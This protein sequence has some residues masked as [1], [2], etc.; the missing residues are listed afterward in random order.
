MS[1]HTNTD[2]VL[3]RLPGYLKKDED[4]NNYKFVNAFEGEFAGIK[5]Q[6]DN[7]KRSIQINTA[8][9]QDLDDIGELFL[10]PRRGNEP[11]ND[12]RAR[13]KAFWQSFSG[14]GTEPSIKAALSRTLGIDEDDVTVTDLIPAKFQV[15]VEI[16]DQFDLIDTVNEVVQE[17]KAAGTFARV[18]AI[19]TLQE[20]VVFSDTVGTPV[21][22]GL[23]MIEESLIDGDD[24]IG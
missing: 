7:L 18:N 16:Q 10:L 6:I 8:S 4:S 23:F 22:D 21:D 20:T 19:A 15:D 5:L 11:D 17:A 12:Y 14:G 13:I 3:S 9:G 1:N 2:K 24:L